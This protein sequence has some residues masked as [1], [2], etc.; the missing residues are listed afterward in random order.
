[1]LNHALRTENLV[2]GEDWF[3]NKRHKSKTIKVLNSIHGRHLKVRFMDDLLRGHEMPNQGL[4]S[5]PKDGVS[6]CKGSDG[7]L[8]AP[9]PGCDEHRDDNHSAKVVTLAE[10]GEDDDIGKLTLK[11]MHQLFRKSAPQ[12]SSKE[13]SS[14]VPSVTFSQEASSNSGNR[15]LVMDTIPTLDCSVQLGGLELHLDSSTSNSAESGDDS[16]PR[17]VATSC[18]KSMDGVVHECEVV[19]REVDCPGLAFKK[20]KSATNPVVCKSEISIEDDDCTLEMWQVYKKRTSCGKKSRR[21]AVEQAPKLEKQTSCEAS[22]TSAGTVGF[23]SMDLAPDSFEYLLTSSSG[24]SGV[25]PSLD[26]HESRSEDLKQNNSLKVLSNLITTSDAI[27]GGGSNSDKLHS[28]VVNYEK[29]TKSRENLSGDEGKQEQ[30][31]LICG[32]SPICSLVDTVEGKCSSKGSNSEKLHSD[33][34]S[35]ESVEISKEDVRTCESKQKHSSLICESSPVCSLVD[36]PLEEESERDLLSTGALSWMLR[37]CTELS[38]TGVSPSFQSKLESKCVIAQEPIISSEIS[39]GPGHV[40]RLA[41]VVEIGKRS[42]AEESCSSKDSCTI[43]PG[44]VDSAEAVMEPFVHYSEDSPPI[45]AKLKEGFGSAEQSMNSVNKVSQKSIDEDTFGSPVSLL[46]TERLDAEEEEQ[47]SEKP[48]PSTIPCKRKA[49]SPLSRERLLL[50]SKFSDRERFSHDSDKRGLKKLPRAFKGFIRH[51]TFNPDRVDVYARAKNTVMLESSPPAKPHEKE[52]ILPGSPCHNREKYLT[53][54]SFL[55]K[56]SPISSSYG[57][58]VA[59]AMIQPNMQTSSPYAQRLSLVLNSS[60]SPPSQQSLKLINGKSPVNT[61]P[62]FPAK[63]ILRSSSPTCQGACKCEEC[64]SLRCRAEKAAE[65]SQRQMHDIEGLAVK[66]LK[67]LNTMRRVV[68]ESLIQR[69]ALRTDSPR[70]ALS[71]EKVKKA[72]SNAFETEKMAKSWLVRMARDCN[73][74]CKIMRMQERKLTFAD[75]SG[76]QLCHVKLFHSQPQ[77]Q[78]KPILFNDVTDKTTASS[79]NANTCLSD[80]PTNEVEKDL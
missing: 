47:E 34:L 32:S 19:T 80:E 33:M 70:T 60:P 66:L 29:S 59:A 55:P 25:A 10:D 17:G 8:N 22:L 73:R 2:E 50:A 21:C 38:S 44:V 52:D 9:Q 3:M 6:T 31:S 78:A 42:M 14:A 20:R 4:P 28:E 45:L 39:D 15:A 63:G 43:K 48:K 49:I 1:M 13:Q 24:L 36:S 67:E 75:E 62:S 12:K 30:S 56:V 40:L 27:E 65:F 57:G 54:K 69:N 58:S 16:S 26:N 46:S 18:L 53:S 76:G 11:E 7:V 23:C 68:E 51:D 71:L 5:R 72:A 64:I 35:N 74:Y 61:S 79:E 41:S 77:A 37:P